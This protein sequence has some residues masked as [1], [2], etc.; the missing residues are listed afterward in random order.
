VVYIDRARFALTTP[1]TH[2]QL[3]LLASI[4]ITLPN[5]NSTPQCQL[6]S[7][8]DICYKREPKGQKQRAVLILAKR[9]ICAMFADV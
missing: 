2:L 6:G 1:R 3:V 5:V 7:S 4:L 8:W 9:G